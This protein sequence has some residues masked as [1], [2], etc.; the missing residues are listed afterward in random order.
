MFVGLGIPRR[1][2][3]FLMRRRLRPILLPLDSGL[4]DLKGLFSLLSASVRHRSRLDRHMTM[5]CI[6]RDLVV[7]SYVVGRFRLQ[8]LAFLLKQAEED[9]RVRGWKKSRRQT[10]E[11]QVRL[12]HLPRQ[13]PQNEVVLTFCRSRCRGRS[14][15]G[16]GNRP[17]ISA[18]SLQG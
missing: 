10:K 3:G 12:D 17:G 11:G 1:Q 4:L 13:S 8:I 14:K 5:T 16:C 6:V 18:F 9:R 7:I 15:F 2:I